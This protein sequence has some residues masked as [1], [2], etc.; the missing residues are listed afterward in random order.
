MLWLHRVSNPQHFVS[1]NY[2]LTEIWV[3]NSLRHEFVSHYVSRVWTSPGVSNQSISILH[4]FS[5][6]NRFIIVTS[7]STIYESVQMNMLID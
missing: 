1:Q 6:F 7:L 3:S 2:V 4:S 5:H